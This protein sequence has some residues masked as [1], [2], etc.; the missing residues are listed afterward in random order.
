[1]KYPALILLFMCSMSYGQS[2][3]H[4]LKSNDSYSTG[5]AKVTNSASF[6]SSQIVK[7]NM[8]GEQFSI[9]KDWRLVSVVNEK[10]GTSS[11]S[12]Y[13]MFFQDSKGGVHSLGVQL[14][15]SISGGNMIYIPAQ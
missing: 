13:V 5:I 4:G 6:Q 14:S 3:L 2:E 11:S 7:K 12:D 8:N 15:G 10:P 9:P 1:M